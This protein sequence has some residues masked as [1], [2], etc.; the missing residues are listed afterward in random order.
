MFGAFTHLRKATVSFVIS[1]CLSICVSVRPHRTTPLS[2]NGFSQNLIFAYFRKI[3]LENSTLGHN[4]LS[5]QWITTAVTMALKLPELEANHPRSSPTEVKNEQT[6]CT[7]P[8]SCHCTPSWCPQGQLNL[9][10]FT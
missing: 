6:N 9:L 7:L 2:L 8:H 5:L 1:G 4:Q 10:T 3:C